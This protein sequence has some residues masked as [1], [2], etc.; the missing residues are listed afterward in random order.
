MLAIII[1]YFK[2]KFFE[3][4]LRSLANQT[5]KRFK[6]YIGDDS[7]TEDC[8]DLLKNYLGKF[9]FKYYRFESNLGGTSLTKQWERCIALSKDEEWLMLLGDDDVLGENVVE[10]FHRQYEKIISSSNVVRFATVFLNEKDGTISHRYEHPKMEK[11][12][13]F[14]MRKLKNETRSSLSEYI[15]KKQVFLKYKFKDY[16]FGF[17]S[18]DRAWF[19]FSEDKFIYSI[20]ESV[21]SI[22]LSY[23]N[24]S[25][26]SDKVLSRKAEFLYLK[27]FYKNKMSYL[28]KSNK[29]YVLKKIESYFYFSKESSF[30]L[31]FPLYIH[32]WRNFDFYEIYKFHRRILF[33]IIRIQTEKKKNMK[34]SFLLW[35]L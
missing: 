11:G 14:F 5:D 17:Y 9:E 24:L 22:R 3:A 29:L 1:P 28:S 6:V 32:F 30:K 20:N 27:Y 31:W 10:E 16:P 12:L 2:L 34:K 25:G 8:T 26:N 23:L 33:E 7:S 19:D 4:T 18:D 15:F 13:E 35:F 21:V